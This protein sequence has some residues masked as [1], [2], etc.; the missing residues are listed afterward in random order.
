MLG[1]IMNAMIEF[2]KYKK[3]MKGVE[4]LKEIYGNDIRFRE[5]KSYSIDEFI[6]F[7]NSVMKVLNYSD[8][9]KFQEHFAPIV[10]EYLMKKYPD[11]PKKYTDL[12]SFLL[13]IPRIHNSIPGA[14]CCEIGKIKIIESSD[15]EK[16]ITME[17]VSSY[18]L[19][20]A[21]FL[22]LIKESAK[23]YKEHVDI[24][25]V[26]KMTEGADKTVVKIKVE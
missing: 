13:N 16:E 4:K 18:K 5:L 3:G 2:V 24:R 21:L 14:F 6:K 1:L 19:L 8:V 23:Y 12:Y 20:D 17:Y 22:T 10:F 11:I 9:V 26:S 7:L 25:I 15:D